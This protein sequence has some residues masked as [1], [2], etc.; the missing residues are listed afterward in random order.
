MNKKR[1]LDERDFLKKE[2][3]QII[4]GR[5]GNLPQW[6]TLAVLELVKLEVFNA[7]ELEEED[8]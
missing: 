8:Q 3:W 1:E 4:T 5:Y 2:L 6:D 7:M